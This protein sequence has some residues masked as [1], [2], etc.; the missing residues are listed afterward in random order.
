MVR[1]K[2]GWEYRG[3]NVSIQLHVLMVCL[4]WQAICYQYLFVLKA[5][6]VSAVQPWSHALQDWIIWVSLLQESESNPQIQIT[7]GFND[8]LSI[9]WKSAPPQGWIPSS[10][11]S[12]S[13]VALSPSLLISPHLDLDSTSRAPPL[14]AGPWATPWPLRKAGPPSFLQPL[15]IWRYC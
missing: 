1:V 9:S 11:W 12:L 7:T 8:L 4:T 3:Q 13:S 10:R 6:H 5:L 15:G 2:H 14:M